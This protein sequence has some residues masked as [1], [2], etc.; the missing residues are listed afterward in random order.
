MTSGNPCLLILALGLALPVFA[1]S[2][3]PE[4]SAQQSNLAPEADAQTPVQ[5]AI[6]A[7]PARK[8]KNPPASQEDRITREVRHELVMQPITPS[9]IG[10]PFAST[11]APWSCWA[12]P[13]AFSSTMS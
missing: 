1:H 11:A 13:T 3:A 12:M 4:V 7:L 8:P 9:G 2:S 6:P 5:D 10:W